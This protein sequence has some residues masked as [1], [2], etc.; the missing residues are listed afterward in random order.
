MY[1]LSDL[2]LC[3]HGLQLSVH[4]MPKPSRLAQLPSQGQ[5]SRGPAS[6]FGRLGLTG[7]SESSTEVQSGVPALCLGRDLSN[8]LI[9]L[10]CEHSSTCLHYTVTSKQHPR[11][12]PTTCMWFYLERVKSTHTS[13]TAFHRH[14]QLES[15]VCMGP[16]KEIFV[17]QGIS[18]PQGY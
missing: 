11:S 15:L 4:Y 6:L 5:V 16:R 1:G 18:F 2:S 3:L 9:T 10:C 12:Q 14:Q 13:S 17:L 7:V 8:T